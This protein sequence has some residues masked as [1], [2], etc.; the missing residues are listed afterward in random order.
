MFFL[1]EKNDLLV[2][3]VK[4]FE[5]CSVVHGYHYFQK[6]W[7]PKANQGLDCAHEV[8]NLYNHFAI[9]TCTRRRNGHTVRYMPMESSRHT[10]YILQWG[11]TVVATLQC[12][13]P[14]IKEDHLWFKVV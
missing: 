6:Y 10:K 13:H 7:E 11:A 8:D 5:F 4:P 12:F 1:E 3:A 9:K 2:M 14:V